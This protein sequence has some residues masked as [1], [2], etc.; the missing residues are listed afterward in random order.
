MFRLTD[1]EIQ[2][3]ICP[4]RGKMSDK[5]A[6]KILFTVEKEVSRAT[7]K[8]IADKIEDMANDGDSV[9]EVLKALRGEI[10]LK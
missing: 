8:K 9:G 7:V 10:E 6:K 1:D 2:G 3:I 5:L 4:Y